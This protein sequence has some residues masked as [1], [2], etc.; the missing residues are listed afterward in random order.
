[1]F[2]ETYIGV[3]EQKINLNDYLNA[4]YPVSLA[5]YLTVNLDELFS[6]RQNR[7][8]NYRQKKKFLKNN[9]GGLLWYNACV[10]HKLNVPIS[11]LPKPEVE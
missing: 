1:M 6:K 8:W 4:K 3:Y 10:Y 2:N 9:R 7:I 5:G 11:R